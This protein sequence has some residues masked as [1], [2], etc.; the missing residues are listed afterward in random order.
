[1]KVIL[2]LNG[3]DKNFSE[4]FQKWKKKTAMATQALIQ[5]ERLKTWFG[6][7]NLVITSYLE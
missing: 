2:R 4:N 6:D 3:K 5:M 1:M 7:L